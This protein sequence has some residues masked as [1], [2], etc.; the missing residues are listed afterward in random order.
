MVMRRVM[1]VLAVVLCCTCGY[2]MAATTTTV[3]AGQPKAVMAYVGSWMDVDFNVKE[4]NE[5]KCKGSSDE[6]PIM[7]CNVWNKNGSPAPSPEQAPSGNA[8]APDLTSNVVGGIGA[9]RPGSSAHEREGGSG[10]LNTEAEV[11]AREVVRAESDNSPKDPASERDSQRQTQESAAPSQGNEETSNDARD[12]NTSDD[13]NPTEQSPAAAVPTA[14]ESSNENDTTSQPSTEN[15]VS[16]EST[17]T[18]SRDSNLTQHSTATDDVTTVPN[19]PETN[20]TN[21]LSPENTT[22]E[23]PTTTTSP[24]PVPNAEISSNIASTVQKNKANVDSS[25]VSPVWM[26]TAAPLLIMVVLFSATVY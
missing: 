11:E 5:K 13:S 22:T 19:S 9:G 17:V 21:P 20:T 12:I 14:T 10:E 24:A 2:T 6:T 23:A 16:E 4:S 1:C 15:T 25:S 3:N 7:G 18:S 26:R 8:R